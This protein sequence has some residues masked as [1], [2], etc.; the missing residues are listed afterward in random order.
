MTKDEKEAMYTSV[1]GNKH[2]GITY[3]FVGQMI[4][5][6]GVK[7]LLYAWDK[8]CKKYT[9]DKLLLVGNGTQSEDLKEKFKNLK[10]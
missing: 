3:I 7:E 8:H 10:F 9:E 2:T 1:I 5:R 4:P 6:K